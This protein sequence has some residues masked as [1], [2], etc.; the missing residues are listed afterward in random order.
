[1]KKL[2]SLL[3]AAALLLALAACSGNTA[4]TSATVRVRVTEVSREPTDDLEHGHPRRCSN[5]AGPG[6][7]RRSPP[8]PWRT[9]ISIKGSRSFRG[10]LLSGIIHARAVT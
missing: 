3:L 7:P 5:N 4:E 1:M 8:W 6:R 9:A 2:F 10:T